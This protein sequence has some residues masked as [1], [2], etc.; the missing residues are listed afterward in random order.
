[1]KRTHDQEGVADMTASTPSAQS[2]G[3]DLPTEAVLSQESAISNISTTSAD[4]LIS[5]ISSSLDKTS[6]VAKLQELEVEKA[7][8]VTRFDGDIAALKRVLSFM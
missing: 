5:S 4:Q 3:N 2:F 8:A 7:K 1:M 6:L